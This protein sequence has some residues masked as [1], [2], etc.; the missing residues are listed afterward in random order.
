VIVATDGK[1]VLLDVDGIEVV[2]GEVV[3]A[4]RGVSLRVEEG[5]IVALLGANG[6][7]KTTTLKAVSRLI[8]AERGEVVRGSIA[9][10]GRD[11]LG[12]GPDRL[13]SQGLVQVLEGRRCFQ[14]LTVQENLLA[15]TLGVRSSR[16]QR[17]ADV[18]RTYAHFPRLR[19]RRKSLA[20]YLSGGE[21]QMLA[22]G[23]ALMSHPRLVLL[24]EPSMGLAPIVVQEIFDIVGELNRSERVSFLLAEQN[25]TVALRYAHWGY[26]LETGR[27]VSDGSA[28]ALRERDDIKQFY[29]GLGDNGRKTFLDDRYARAGGGALS[30]VQAPGVSSAA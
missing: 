5:S 11:I 4:L 27:V 17:A 10:D 14:H 16:G 8:G 30:G 3:L 22:I 13:V 15:G 19:E 28:E 21:Q 12:T 26:V 6:A 1:K 23:R 29:L 25:A 18:E 2:Y 9:Y 24:D 7:G 20:G